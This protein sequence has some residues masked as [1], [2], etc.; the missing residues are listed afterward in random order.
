MDKTTPEI[1]KLSTFEL[2]YLLKVIRKE[3]RDMYRH[4]NS[5]YKAGEQE[6]TDEF[7]EYERIAGQN[8]MYYTKKVFVVE[9][10]M[11]LS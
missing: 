8:Y 9:N 4:M 3:R 5:F 6:S 1:M 2:L 11:V 7:K 10:S